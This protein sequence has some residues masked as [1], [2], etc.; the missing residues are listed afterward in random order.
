[1]LQS[2]A[3]GPLWRRNVSHAAE[4]PE[5]DVMSFP[6]DGPTGQ[7]M[8]EFVRQHDGEQREDFQCAFQ[9][10]RWNTREDDAG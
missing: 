1:M 7:L 9:V 2:C 3:P 10:S 6:A 8:A 4:R 5:D